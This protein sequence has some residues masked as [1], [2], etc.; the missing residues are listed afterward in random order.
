MNESAWTDDEV[1][2]LLK[3]GVVCEDLTPAWASKDFPKVLRIPQNLVEA[4]D[5]MLGW[6]TPRGWYIT[7][8]LGFVA[9]RYNNVLLWTSKKLT[10]TQAI[11]EHIGGGGSIPED[12]WYVVTRRQTVDRSRF[13][14]TCRKCSK[15]AYIGAYDVECSVKGCLGR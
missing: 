11:T 4:G 14:H 2:K 12:L 8:R 9:F 5:C 1:F 7:T 10:M 15:P 6:V 3:I 13:P